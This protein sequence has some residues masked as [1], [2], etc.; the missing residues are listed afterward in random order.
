M[1][2]FEQSA[3]EDAAKLEHVC[4][5]VAVDF[6]F[7][8]GHARFWSGVGEIT[9]GGNTYTGAGT[10]GGISTPSESTSLVAEKKTYRLSGADPSI[11]AESDIDDSFGRTVTEYFGFL[12]PTTRQLL[13]EP[14]INWEGR[15]DS[16]RR[17]DGADPVIEVNAEHRMVMLDR[18]DGWRYTQQHQEKFFSSDLGFNLIGTLETKEVLWGGKRAWD[19]V[20][21]GRTPSH[22]EGD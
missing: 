1:S 8:S 18:N 21:R 19:G 4:M 3:N 15:I 9:I 17:V 14:E 10:L 7:P 5:F 22:Y 16:F 2:W 11:I 6:D 13:A 12:N 20:K